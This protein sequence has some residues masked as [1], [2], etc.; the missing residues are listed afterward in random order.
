MK[1]MYEVADTTDEDTFL[2]L[3]VFESLHDAV[4]AIKEIEAEGKAISDNDSW[5]TIS[6]YRREVGWSGM[7]IPVYIVERE[8]YYDE[9]SGEYR[10]CR[11]EV[12]NEHS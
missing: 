2:P 10:W 11:V 3:G 4:T 1:Y 9:V 12:R 7:G 6:V 8:E 5:E